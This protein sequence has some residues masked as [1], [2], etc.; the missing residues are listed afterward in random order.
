MLAAFLI[1]LVVRS[2]PE[3]LSGPFPLGLDTLNL[4]PKIQSGWVF[5]LSPLGFLNNISMFYVF[6][7]LLYALTHNIVFVLKFLGPVLSAVICGLMFLYARK[8]LNWSN[9]KSLLVSILT[10]TYFVALRDS[11]DL[12]RQSMGLIFLMAALISLKSFSS[13]RKYYIAGS[14]MVLTVLSH[15]LTTVVLLFII[16]VEVA[17]S[18]IKKSPRD[19]IYLLVSVAAAFALFLFQILS[20]GV[21]ANYI[22]NSVASGPSVAL[23]LLM[24]GLLFYSYVVILPL[25]LVGLEGFKVSAMHYWALL[26]VGIVL[27]EVVDPNFPLFFWNRWVYLLV[28]PL[29]FFAAQ[30]FGRIWKFWYGHKVKVRRLVPKVFAISYLVLLLTLSGFYLAAS[31]ENQISFFSTNNQYLTFIPSSMLQNTLSI[32]D[33]PS[34]VKC[35]EWINNT[36]AENS[37]VVI[38]YALEDLALIYVN[39]RLVIPVYQKTS[40]LSYIQNET[41]IVDGMI[42]A[43]LTSLNATHSAVFTVWWVSGKGW[44]G[45][46]SLPAEFSEVFHS[47]NM[48]VYLY[49]PGI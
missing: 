40:M 23:A 13:P 28:Y 17:R 16:L 7:G 36:T 3:V 29:L 38:H 26:C 30:G 8:G 1:P 33:N 9:R 46:P 45:I 27:I 43:A 48:A 4:I 32:S 21:G 11:W 39:S 20:S 12:Y 47:G 35:F 10:A 41:T 31:P 22:P 6:A 49:N 42:A 24:A 2:I 44:Y 19:S 25:V 14:F 37:S 34:L 15:E 18:L 5:S